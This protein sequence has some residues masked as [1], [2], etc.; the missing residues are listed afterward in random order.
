MSAVRRMRTYYS[1][2]VP[3]EAMA[4][5]LRNAGYTVVANGQ[6]KKGFRRKEKGFS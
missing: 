3:L 2:H 1:D 6:G 4:E 5:V